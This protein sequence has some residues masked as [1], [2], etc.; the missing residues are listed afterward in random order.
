ME[1]TVKVTFSDKSHLV[2]GINGTMEAVKA[3]YLGQVFVEE[4]PDGREVARTAVT[5]EE[6]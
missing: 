6:C 3:Y 4:G 5:V 2:T 1:R